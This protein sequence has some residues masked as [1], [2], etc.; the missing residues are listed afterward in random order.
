M[1][2]SLDPARVCALAHRALEGLV[3]ALEAAPEP[4]G[5]GIDGVPAGGGGR[6]PAGR[7]EAR[8]A[9]PERA[10]GSIDV[11][12][13]GERARVLEEWNRTTAEYPAGSRV[14]Q[15]TEAPGGRTARAGAG[16]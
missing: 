14:H 2:A 12:P 6:V 3:E 7:G 9:A 15:A 4:A 13:A 16:G 8:G 11:L 5:G 1:H 10:V